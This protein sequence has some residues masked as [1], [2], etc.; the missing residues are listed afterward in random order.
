M[1]WQ[2]LAN[3]QRSKVTADIQ[4]FQNNNDNDNRTF[5]AQSNLGSQSIN[6]PLKRKKKTKPKKKE[7]KILRKKRRKKTKH[8]HRETN[9]DKFL[10]S[11]VSR[12]HN[13]RNNYRDRKKL[14]KDEKQVS[15]R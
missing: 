3:R 11:K 6:L 10:S 5:L 12:P 13:I 8:T 14:K 7:K 9:T 1:L 15:S 4:M 2:S